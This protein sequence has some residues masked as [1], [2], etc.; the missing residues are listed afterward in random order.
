VVGGPAAEAT[1]LLD[2]ARRAFGLFENLEPEALE[3]LTSG[4]AAVR[5]PAGETMFRPG[6]GCEGFGFVVGGA[7]K[8]GLVSEHGR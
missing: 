4:L 3:L 2:V 5:L 1:G 7:V 6:D 8:V